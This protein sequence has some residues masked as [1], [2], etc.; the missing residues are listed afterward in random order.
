MADRPAAD[1]HLV[2]A[3]CMQLEQ[4]LALPQST[5]DQL[6]LALK[7]KEA[8]VTLTVSLAEKRILRYLAARAARVRIEHERTAE[9]FLNNTARW[10]ALATGGGWE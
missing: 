2:L 10:S 8:S 3:D 4:V 5:A 6:L 7:Q 1:A 9:T